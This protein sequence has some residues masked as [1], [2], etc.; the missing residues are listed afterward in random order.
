MALLLPIALFTG[1]LVAGMLLWSAIGGVPWMRRLSGAE[2][3]RLHRFWSPRFDPLGP[4][5]VVV[6][7]AADLAL[8]TAGTARE[9]RPA[10]TVAVAALTG[11]I[12]VSAARAAPLKRRVTALDPD[13]LPDDFA[14]RD[15]RA[16]WQRWNLIR[17]VL[18]VGA[19]AANTVAVG[20]LLPA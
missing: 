1:G 3:V 2:Y 12:I 4:I 8:L 14:A 15:P 16:A 17:T 19:F 6:T 18:A 11:V 5:A 7:A 13:R 20:L 10:L 9:A